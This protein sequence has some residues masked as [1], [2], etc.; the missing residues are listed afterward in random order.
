MTTRATADKH[1][2]FSVS[3]GKAELFVSGYWG[4]PM[5]RANP[6]I[7]RPAVEVKPWNTQA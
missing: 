2:G 7:T 3:C 1:S 5:R 6:K 4:R